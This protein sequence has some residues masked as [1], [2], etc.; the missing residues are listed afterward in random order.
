[1]GWLLRIYDWN[2]KDSEAYIRRAIEL[3]PNEAMNYRRLAFLFVTLG[4]T[5]EAVELSSHAKML[6]PLDRNHPWLLYCDRQFDRSAVEYAAN[7]SANTSE[8]IINDAKMG[9]AMSY[10]EIGRANESHVLLEELIARNED[11]FAVRAIYAV[12]LFRIGDGER[13][14]KELAWLERKAAESPGR[15]VRLA[16]VYAAK[17]DQDNVI[18]ALQLGLETRD[19][20]LMWIKTTPYFD[21]FRDDPRFAEIVAKMGLPK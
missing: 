8:D 1:M 20:R 12:A 18:R 14:L 5:A 15:W 6:D 16:Y 17:G 10:L 19:D 2:W 3:A 21:A 9:I 13:A 7:L 11:G 4:R